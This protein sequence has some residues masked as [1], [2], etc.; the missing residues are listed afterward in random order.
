[1]KLGII[2]FLA[3]KALAGYGKQSLLLDGVDSVHVNHTLP[4]K[5]RW[6]MALKA[7][8]S[9]VPGPNLNPR[10]NNGAFYLDV[11]EVALILRGHEVK[12]YAEH[13]GHRTLVSMAD[14][15]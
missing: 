1:M 11:R 13:C 5:R 8:N 10:N 12:V 15:C 2:G 4:R 3:P 14:L 9:S 6:K 7:F